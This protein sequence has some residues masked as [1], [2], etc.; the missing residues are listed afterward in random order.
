VCAPG[1][2]T[3]ITVNDGLTN[4]PANVIYGDLASGEVIMHVIDRVLLPPGMT[5]AQVNKAIAAAD[6]AAAEA[7]AVPADSPATLEAL[8]AGAGGAAAVPSPPPKSSAAGVAVS[9]AAALAPA[10]LLAML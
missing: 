7:A 2:P 4:T 10:V 8:P 6:A 1:T 3:G 5:M 9:V